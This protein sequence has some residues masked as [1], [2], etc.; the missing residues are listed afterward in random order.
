MAQCPT[1]G[2]KVPD[3]ADVCPDCGMDLQ[4]SPPL[5]D[6][7]AAPPA[8]APAVVAEPVDDVASLAPTSEEI[9]E[10]AVE[11][12]LD[13]P[14]PGIDAE[15]AAPA[16]APAV[17]MLGTRD[18]ATPLRTDVEKALAEGASEV[19]VDFEGLLVTQSFM[20]EFLGVLILRHGPGILDRITLANCHD[21][22]KVTAELVTFIRSRDFNSQRS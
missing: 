14:M 7:P 13:L 3:D 9:V 5:A 4:S 20:D 21:D 15:A 1:C 22:V 10:G 2:S 12:A 19:C 18:V 8:A 16:P 11:D 6:A 17:F